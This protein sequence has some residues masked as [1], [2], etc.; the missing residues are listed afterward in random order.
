M[1]PRRQ[2]STPSG[3]RYRQVSLYYMLLILGWKSVSDMTDSRLAP[4][5][6]E[7]SLQC[8]AISHWLGANLESALSQV[9]LSKWLKQPNHSKQNATKTT[10]SISI[11]M[12]WTLA[13]SSTVGKLSLQ[14]ASSFATVLI[15][16]SILNIANFGM[17]LIRRLYCM[18]FFKI[19]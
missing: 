2:R 9:T 15:S 4:N 11:R 14:F 1:S 8:N 3:G 17:V 13:K 10:D 5:Q 19:Y 16:I 12:L 18:Q 7:T 6:W